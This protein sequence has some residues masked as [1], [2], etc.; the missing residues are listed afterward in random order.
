M[1]ALVSM[2]L[3]ILDWPALTGARGDVRPRKALG[4][5][6]HDGTDAAARR[7][8]GTGQPSVSFLGSAPTMKTTSSSRPEL[9]AHPLR[10]RLLDRGDDILCGPRR[11][12]PQ[13][14]RQRPR[15]GAACAAM[16]RR[17]REK[18][19]NI[20]RP[21]PGLD[22]LVDPTP[23][24]ADRERLRAQRRSRVGTRG[25]LRLP[26][27]QRLAGQRALQDFGGQQGVRVY[28]EAPATPAT[29]S[30]S[31]DANAQRPLA[32]AAHRPELR[33]PR[34]AGPPHLVRRQR[35]HGDAPREGRLAHGAVGGDWT[36]SASAARTT[37]S[38][39]AT[40]AC[41]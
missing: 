6:I 40:T 10:R 1:I 18:P 14:G 21:D 2:G 5:S 38:S 37:S 3:P 15:A 28:G 11:T 7:H 29:T 32:R 26:A 30:I 12:R 9:A 13:L 23:S 25:Q 17:R 20:T 35:P 4:F 19:F 8:L 34:L 22:A 41:I 16:A 33:E 31:R 39:R 36:A 24:R 27:D